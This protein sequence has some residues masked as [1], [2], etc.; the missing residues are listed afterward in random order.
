MHT[1]LIELFK[2]HLKKDNK[3][4][5]YKC[6]LSPKEVYMGPQNPVER[7]TSDVKA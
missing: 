1:Q 5:A 3:L 4:L 6:L 7:H 2:Q